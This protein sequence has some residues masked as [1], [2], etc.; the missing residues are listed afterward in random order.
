MLINRLIDSAAAQSR[1][2]FGNVMGVAGIEAAFI[3]PVMLLIYFGLLDLTNVLSARD[4]DGK[5]AGRSRHAVERHHHKG[6][7]CGILS[8]LDSHH[9]PILDE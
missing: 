6:G 4:A 3:F 2:Y 8:C 7:A 1:E 9:G 5:H